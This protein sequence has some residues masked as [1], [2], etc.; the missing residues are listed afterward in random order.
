VRV[1]LP[2]SSM[3]SQEWLSYSTSSAASSA[4]EANF[5]CRFPALCR[6][7][8]AIQKKSIA[9]AITKGVAFSR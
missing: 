7:N 8:P 6:S 9:T 4:A 2:S 3:H 1:L 5:A